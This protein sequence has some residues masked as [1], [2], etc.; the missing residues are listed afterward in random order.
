MSQP[1]F[2]QTFR[3][4][5]ALAISGV[6]MRLVCVRVYS[7]DAREHVLGALRRISMLGGGNFDLYKGFRRIDV[8][9]N[10]YISFAELGEALADMGQ[11]LSSQVRNLAQA[12][13][14]LSLL[15]GCA[16]NYCCQPSAPPAPAACHGEDWLHE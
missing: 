1:I 4:S 15:Y 2:S 14:P 7:R 9:G 13:P 16:L 3:R 12:T 11:P 5:S 10:G 6:C 8:D